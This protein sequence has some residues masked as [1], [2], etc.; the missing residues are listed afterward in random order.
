MNVAKHTYADV[1]SYGGIHASTCAGL[2]PGAILREQKKSASADE[3]QSWETTGYA[4]R[5]DRTSS[6]GRDRKPAHGW[7]VLRTTYGR[8]KK[9]YEYLVKNNVAAFYPTITQ[10]RLVGG[11]RKN[12]EVSRFPNLFFAYGTEEEIKSFVYDNINLP[13]LRFYYRYY[14]VGNNVVKEPVV[15]P[16][17]QMKSIRIIC[18]GN[19]ENIVVSE[20]ETRKFRTGMPVRII[21]GRFKG[22]TGRVAR[23]QRQQRVA[24]VIEGLLTVATAYIPTAFLEPLVRKGDGLNK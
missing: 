24:V 5:G 2:I 11:K 22:V 17:D 21:D 1:I 12:I 23:V 20:A 10:V 4:Q 16:D 19:T 8:E 14:H 9:A 15:I 3:M 7:Y 6:S 13:Y 18:E